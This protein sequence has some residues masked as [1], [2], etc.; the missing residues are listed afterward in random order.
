MRGRARVWGRRILL[1]LSVPLGVG[2]AVAGNQVLTDAGWSWGWT[3]VAVALAA[4]GALV[5][6]WLTR[7]SVAEPD[8][9]AGG[10]ERSVV[11]SGDNSGII[12]TGDGATNIQMNP[13]R[14]MSTSEVHDEAG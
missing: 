10:G 9:P 1:V 3:G 7:P 6:F 2:T 8:P 13:R 12:S 14:G 5:A 11:V 4:A